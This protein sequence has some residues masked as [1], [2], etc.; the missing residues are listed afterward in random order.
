MPNLHKTVTQAAAI[1]KHQTVFL[2]AGKLIIYISSS[3]YQVIE[4]VCSIIAVSPR[5]SS[6]NRL[7]YTG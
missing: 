6:L 7:L 5:Q 1:F 3:P 4:Q 2:V